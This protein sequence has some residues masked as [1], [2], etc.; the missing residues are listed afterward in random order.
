MIKIVAILA[1]AMLM[2][3]P[4]QAQ[5][6]ASELFAVT[7]GSPFKVTPSVHSGNDRTLA[8]TSSAERPRPS[9]TDKVLCKAAFKAAPQN[10]TLT[11]AAINAH[12]QDG[13]WRQAART[14]LGQV[15]KLEPETPFMDK[16]IAGIE[17]VGAPAA[18]PDASRVRVYL[19]LAETPAGRTSLSCAT[20]VED[21]PAALPVFR[22]VRGAITMPK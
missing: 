17:F 2:L 1:G 13:K 14:A 7:L 15:F 5:T 21:L 18:G 9:N 3:A 11:Q 20:F 22:T 16:G 8:I 12:V 19:T 6:R 10:G 4:A